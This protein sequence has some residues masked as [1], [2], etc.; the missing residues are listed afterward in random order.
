MYIIVYLEDV[1]KNRLF[2]L[3][4]NVRRNKLTQNKP[5][6]LSVIPFVPFMLSYTLFH[7]E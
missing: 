2:E 6:S 5:Q 4:R 1:T 3:N 7:N